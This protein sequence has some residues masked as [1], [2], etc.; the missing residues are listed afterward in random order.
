MPYLLFEVR[1]YDFSVER[2][3]S[4]A[5]LSAL[6]VMVQAC[7]TTRSGGTTWALLILGLCGV[8]VRSCARVV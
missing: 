6:P 5:D 3:S 7:R 2:Y 4:I 1:V 8:T